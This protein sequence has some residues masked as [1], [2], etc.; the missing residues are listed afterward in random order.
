MPRH[1]SL[2][3]RSKVVIVQNNRRAHTIWV[4]GVRGVVP[5]AAPVPRGVW[6]FWGL[7]VGGWGLRVGGW[8]SGIGVWV[9][10]FGDRVLGFEV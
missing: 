9:L 7:G 1:A 5:G 3:R 6:G 4:T 2:S 8:G 10:D